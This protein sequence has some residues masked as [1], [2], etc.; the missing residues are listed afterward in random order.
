MLGKLIKHE[1]RATGRI[2]LPVLAAVLALS[3]AAGLSVK[4]IG[5]AHTGFTEMMYSMVIVLFC[6]SLVAVS[7]VVF[8]LMIQRF[9][10]SLL[11]DEGYLFFTLPATADEII[12]SRLI[13]SS[14][15]FLVTALL[16]AAAMLIMGLIS[17][18]L[19]TEIFGGAGD[20]SFSELLAEAL[21]QFGGGS[22]AAGRAHVIGYALELIVIVF[23]GGCGFCLQFYAPISMG[24]SFSNHK[25]L[26]SVVFF[27]AL[28]IAAQI[29]S[30]AFISA[31][32]W[33]SIANWMAS[34]VSPDMSG[35]AQLIHYVMLF[36]IAEELIAGGICYAIT[37]I[38]LR[39]RLNLP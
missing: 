28:G 18:D 24:Y 32:N 8:V 12:W 33:D 34:N 25:R 21:R 2:M 4:A 7:V 17:A 22:V 35:M 16:C 29:L 39:K 1:F 26:L 10:R 14:V 11:G 15:W 38:F 13:V 36:A 31:G 23:L 9:S 30:T 6:V 5:D 19:G 27:F 37:S 3:V 20:M